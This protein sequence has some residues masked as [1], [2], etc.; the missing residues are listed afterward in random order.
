MM[1]AFLRPERQSRMKFNDWRHILV[2]GWPIQCLEKGS[3]CEKHLFARLE[4][5]KFLCNHISLVPPYE[6]NS[7]WRFLSEIPE[8]FD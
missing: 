6:P 3:S 5:L 7:I 1:S 2:L 4:N 8:T